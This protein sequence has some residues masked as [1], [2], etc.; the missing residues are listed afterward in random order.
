MH[1]VFLR[2]D[3]QWAVL[4]ASCSSACVCPPS[5]SPCC[6]RGYSPMSCGLYDLE[7][8]IVTRIC[9]PDLPERMPITAALMGS[10]GSAGGCASCTPPP[11]PPWLVP[12][13]YP[14]RLYGARP[15]AT[16]AP[17][18]WWGPDCL[19]A[20][21]PHTYPLRSRGAPQSPKG[22]PG[23]AGLKWG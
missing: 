6:S 12:S 7:L 8:H 1:C 22:I 17:L 23:G 15:G 16:T 3:W 13:G 5:P 21:F 4:A 11:P 18:H 9:P 20:V 14:R 19:L 10:P 2:A